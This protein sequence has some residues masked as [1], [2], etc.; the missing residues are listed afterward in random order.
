[1]SMHTVY[2]KDHFATGFEPVV[3]DAINA[4]HACAIAEVLYPAAHVHA[5]Q[6]EAHILEYHPYTRVL[7]LADVEGYWRCVAQAR[8]VAN[9]SVRRCYGY[10]TSTFCPFCG[11]E[12]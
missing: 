6:N 5:V 12:S 4:D 7:S 11:S 2:L 8:Q 10:A 9:G 3:V 1:M